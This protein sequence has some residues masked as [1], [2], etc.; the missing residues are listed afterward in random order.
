MDYNYGHPSGSGIPSATW[1]FNQYYQPLP[2][3]GPYGYPWTPEFTHINP[4]AYHGR[5]IPGMGGQMYHPNQQVYQQPID[6]GKQIQ[7]SNLQP[8]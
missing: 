1:P 3:Y 8:K 4:F 5:Y 6:N 2:G 7:Q